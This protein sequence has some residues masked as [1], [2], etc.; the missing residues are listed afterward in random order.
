MGQGAGI[1][2]AGL[3]DG[4]I[5]LVPLLELQ[6]IL[7]LVAGVIAYFLLPRYRKTV[8]AETDGQSAEPI[9]GSQQSAFEASGPRA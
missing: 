8:A 6:G 7:Y 3:A 1:L 2:L 9:G 5:G 4:P